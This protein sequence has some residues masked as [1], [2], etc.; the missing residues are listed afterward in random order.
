MLKVIGWELGQLVTLS[1]SFVISWSALPTVIQHREQFSGTAA[2]QELS[3]G[4]T[5]TDSVDEL[6]L[7]LW[8]GFQEPV[9]GRS[10]GLRKG[11]FLLAGHLPECLHGASACELIL[12][13]F[14]TR[15]IRLPLRGQRRNCHVYRHKNR[16]ENHHAMA[17]MDQPVVIKT[18]EELRVRCE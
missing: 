13:G 8:H 2:G 10:P 7:N 17:Q 9:S 15:S 14:L 6:V 16:H 12:G 18:Q 5:L 1:D 11:E 3:V 4:S